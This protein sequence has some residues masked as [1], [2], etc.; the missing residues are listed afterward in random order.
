MTIGKFGFE[1]EFFFC[2]GEKDGPLAE[3]LVILPDGLRPYADSCGYLL[4]A[5]GEPHYDPNKARWLL[6]ATICELKN[7]ALK[8]G[9]RLMNEDSVDLPRKYILSVL[10]KFG[11][12]VS[13]SS[14]MYGR[15]YASSR[16]RAGLHIHFSNQITVDGRNGPVTIS[17][18]MDIPRIIATMDGIF[19]DEIK[20]ARRIPGEYEMKTHGFEYRSLPA[21]VR[22]ENVVSALEEIRRM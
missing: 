22:L 2:S 3:N 1:L 15:G 21:T 8:Y 18:Q 6:H 20:K 11:K 12:G 17:Q 16:P 10:R 19:H 7:A 13:K 5:R 14:F 9:L 4:E